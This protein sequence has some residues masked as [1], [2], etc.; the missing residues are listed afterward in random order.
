[1]PK[2]A[3]LHEEVKLY[4]YSKDKY[5]LVTKIENSGIPYCDY[6]NIRYKKVIE[7][8]AESNCAIT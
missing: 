3:H 4:F 7:T 5:V 2:Q 8:I 1:M 6:F